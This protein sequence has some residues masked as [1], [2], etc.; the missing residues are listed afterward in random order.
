[1]KASVLPP[2]TAS[3]IRVRSSNLFRE[4]LDGHRALTRKETRCFK[5]NGF[6]KLSDVLTTE[7]LEFYARLISDQ[8]THG[9]R[10]KPVK[11]RGAYLGTAYQVANIWQSDAV[12]RDLV[13]SRKLARIAAELLEVSGVR[14]YHDRVLSKEP[15]DG[16]TPWHADQSDWPID[17]NNSITA[18]IPL[19]DTPLSMGPIS[20]AP[21]SHRIRV[22]RG[23]PISDESEAL[24]QQTLNDLKMD[25]VETGYKLGEVSFHRGWNWH[26]AGANTTDQA[27]RVMT[28]IYME[29]D[30]RLIKPQHEHHQANWEAWMP[31]VQVGKVIDSPLNPVLWTGRP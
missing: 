1:M 30:A 28:V 29:E 11:A 31:G 14:L 12:V 18:W 2:I 10:R 20:Y 7:T 17:T 15:G 26:R 8:A 16:I 4:D 9:Q 21:R 23:V 3:A 19:Q 13:F 5:E 27:R 22:G 6:V 25:V 24:I